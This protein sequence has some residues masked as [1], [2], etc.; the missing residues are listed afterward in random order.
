M[1]ITAA[2]TGVYLFLTVREI[3]LG[4]FN[5]LSFAIVTI[6]ALLTILS[7]RNLIV[8]GMVTFG[9]T[10]VLTPLELG[11]SRIS[12]LDT[13]ISVFLFF[14]LLIGAI[15][16][17]VFLLGEKREI[18]LWRIIARPFALLFIPIDVIWGKKILL[19]IIGVVSLFFIFTDIFRFITKAKLSA[20][21]KKGEH[22]RFS[23]M[24]LFLVSI[25]IT[26]LVFP[27]GIA[28]LSLVY[29]S[30]GDLFG[31]L[32][33]M[34]FG[35]IRIYKDKTLE[36]IL[37]F[38]DG[39]ILSGY[40]IYMVVPV[41]LIFLFAGSAFASFVELFSEAIDDNFTISLL[42]GGFLAALRFFFKV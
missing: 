16:R 20:F 18:K 21:F 2:G 30:I 10:A 5:L 11:L 17:G 37:G 27:S 42:S 25:F 32:L 9:F 6:I 26:F 1:I 39:S 4:N 7:S 29:I 33:G 28:Y 38:I 35:T 14:Y 40:I 3:I 36:G 24:T 23:S 19:L 12:I 13:A 34:R 8:T 15:R 41:P 22:S 31:K